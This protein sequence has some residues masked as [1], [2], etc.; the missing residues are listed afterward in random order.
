VLSNEQSWVAMDA[1]PDRENCIAYIAITKALRKLGLIS[2]EIYKENLTAGFLLITDFGDKQLL[3]ELNTSNVS[4]L[5]GEAL[6]ALAML[7]ACKFVDGWNVPVF[8]AAFMLDELKL[9]KQWFLQSYLNLDLSPATELMLTN[10]FDFL[11]NLAASQPMVFMHRDYHSANLMVLP[12]NKIGLL[13]FQDAFIGPVTYDLVSL[14]RDCYID[15]PESLVT[16]L[17]LSY[18][19]C[20][21]L[22]VSDELFLRWFDGMGMQRHM[23]ALLTFSRKYKRDANPHYLKHMPRTLGYISSISKHFEE[24]NDF[25]DF[26]NTVI[27]PAYDKVSLVCEE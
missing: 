2:P 13:D 17:A 26:L 16:E 24:C 9:F 11:A 4:Q 14:L 18:K 6:D 21:N 7:Q 15:W 23:K 22:S 25:C 10:V 8:N 1:P 27:L 3:G 12:Q 19:Q 5:Y 20:I